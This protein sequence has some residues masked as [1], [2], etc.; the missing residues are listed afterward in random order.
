MS[1]P[2][3]AD[4]ILGEKGRLGGD[5]FIHGDCVSIGC[6]A[7]TDAMIDEVY[8]LAVL[9]R[10]RG[11]RRIPVHIFPG[12][13]DEEGMAYF[14]RRYGGALLEF[15][16]NLSVGYRWFEEKKALPKVDVLADGR[17]AFSGT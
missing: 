2:N 11:Q 10:A 17:Y 5:I 3:R 12:R 6:I 8:T 13:L 7:I 4:V 15:W 9:A 14:E 1:Y 16:K